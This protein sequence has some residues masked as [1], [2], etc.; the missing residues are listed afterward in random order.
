MLLFT[1]SKIN[2]KEQGYSN[3]KAVPFTWEQGENLG[4]LSVPIQ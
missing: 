4:L 3:C 2:G 1:V